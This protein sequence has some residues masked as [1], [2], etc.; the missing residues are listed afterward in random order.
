MDLQNLLEDEV[1]VVD[2]KTN[3][4]FKIVEKFFNIKKE[5]YLEKKYNFLLKYLFFLIIIYLL[6]GREQN[7][8]IKIYLMY[9]YLEYFSN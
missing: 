6:Y 1:K 8:S 7:F 2:K 3:Q 9:V 5:E 4:K